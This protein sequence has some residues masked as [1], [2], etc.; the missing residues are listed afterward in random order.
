MEIRNN[1]GF[2]KWL[3]IGISVIF[4]LI[5]LVLP[6][7]YV[8]YTA[9]R[10]GW[11]VFVSSVTDEYAVKSILLTVKVTVIT[12]II[13]SVFGIFAAWLITRFKFRG[14]KIISTLIDLPLTISPIIAGLIFVL[15]FRSSG[16]QFI[17]FLKNGNTDNICCS[18]NSSCDNICDIS[19]YIKRDNTCSYS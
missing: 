15:T 6:L 8:I 9:L 5:M 2:V 13:N 14:K 4:L 1:K 16:V 17:R 7:V 10:E 3:L 11:K 18:R 19:V 12:V